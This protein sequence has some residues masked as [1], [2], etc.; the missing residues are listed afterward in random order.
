MLSLGKERNRLKDKAET[1]EN[2]GSGGFH[3]V[4]FVDVEESH[5]VAA[6]E[7]EGL[8]PE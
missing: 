7:T 6:E 5:A 4:A 1:D 3:L 2:A 8:V